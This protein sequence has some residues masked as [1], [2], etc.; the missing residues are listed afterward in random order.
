MI[1]K[2]EKKIDEKK[3]RKKTSMKRLQNIIIIKIFNV[4]VCVCVSFDF[5][6]NAMS[7]VDDKTIKDAASCFVFVSFCALVPRFFSI[8]IFHPIYSMGHT[9]RA[10]NE[11][12]VL[13][14]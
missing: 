4:C 5:N 13:N 10:I 9:Q 11:M 3:M 6:K 12:I 8:V 7:S 14:S 1:I 2:K